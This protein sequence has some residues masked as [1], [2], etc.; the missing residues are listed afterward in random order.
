MKELLLA[1]LFPPR[2]LVCQKKLAAAQPIMVLCASCLEA[3]AINQTLFCIRCRARLADHERIC[4]TKTPL[5]LAAIG[6]YVD[7]RLRL[8]ITS[9]KYRRQTATLN[10]LSILLDRYLTRLTFKFEGYTVIA[11]PLHRKRERRRGFN[12]SLRIAELVAARL[13]LPLVKDGLIRTTFTVP[14]TQT[15]DRNERLHNLDD[16]FFVPNQQTIAN[17]KILLVDDVCTTGTTLS[18]AAHALKQAGAKQIIGL[19]IAATD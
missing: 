14:Q 19:V 10:T 2:C 17:T 8:L 6:R 5:R 15:K 9:L 7:Q 4:H 13:K 12:Q 1:A 3:V 16:C 18:Q 11:I